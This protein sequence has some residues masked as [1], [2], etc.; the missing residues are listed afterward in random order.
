VYARQVGRQILTFGVSGMLFRDGLVMYDRETDT[1]WTQVDGRAIKGGLRGQTLKIVP[2]IHA[3]WNEWKLLYPQSLVLK[4]RGE[5]RSSY[6]AYNRDPRRMGVLGRRLRDQRLPGRE[7]IIGVRSADGTTAFVE[8][9]VR[10]A[11]LVQA[12]VGS[13]PVVLVAPG[14][15]RPVVAFER[16]VAGRVLS[17]RM[18]GDDPV[19]IV[20]SETDSRWSLAYGE[21]VA[22]PLQGSILPRAPA[23]PAFWFAW[24]GYFPRTEVWKQSP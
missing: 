18:S 6:E 15:S 16:R 13:L 2:S 19:T 21:A 9:D 8:K 5:I 11:K 22:G 17:F 24:Q 12:Q 7:R 20:D 23:Y 14:E 3:T 1:L 4:K 10:A